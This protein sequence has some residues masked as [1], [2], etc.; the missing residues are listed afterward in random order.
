MEKLAEALGVDLELLLRYVDAFASIG[1]YHDS[2]LQA[3]VD[4]SP[5][6]ALKCE[7]AFDEYWFIELSPRTSQN[8]AILMAVKGEAVCGIP[9]H[10]RLSSS[11]L[12]L[13]R[14]S[15]A[16]PS[17]LRKNGTF[18]SWHWSRNDLPPIQIHRPLGRS[19]H[20]LLA[21]GYQ[22]DQDQV[23]L[24]RV[25]R[26]GISLQ[27][28]LVSSNLFSNCIPVD[29]RLL[30]SRRYSAK[31]EKEQVQPNGLLSLSTLEKCANELFAL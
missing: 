4:G 16:P 13:P 9:R 5:V 15:T 8:P 28:A 23:V 11:A 24:L 26:K 20:R 25:R 6:V 7:P 30:P 10:N 3:Y 18:A 19:P 12:S 17:C 27:Q 31:E 2:D 14:L 1:L 21:N 22:L 29:Q